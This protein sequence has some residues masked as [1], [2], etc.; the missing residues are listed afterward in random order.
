MSWDLNK[1]SIPCIIIINT[2]DNPDGIGHPT[3]CFH[4]YI[5]EYNNAYHYCYVTM[6]HVATTRAKN[7]CNNS[8]PQ[9]GLGRLVIAQRR[10]IT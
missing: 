6:L 10:K 7:R 3:L 2:K 8:T 9:K 4:L 1:G 5:L